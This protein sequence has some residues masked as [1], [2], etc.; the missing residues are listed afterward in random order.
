MFSSQIVNALT[1]DPHVSNCFEGV[2]PCD[3]LPQNVDF[4]SAFVANTDPSN[5]KGEHWVCYYFDKNGNAEYFDSFG[6]PPSNCQLYNFFQRN[7]K[8]HKY[9]DVQIQGLTSDSCGQYCIAILANRARG[10][11]L[12]EI[13]KR[14]TGPKPGMY[15]SLIA[16][17]VNKEY[18]IMTSQKK[19]KKDVG[20]GGGYY[21]PEQCCCCKKNWRCH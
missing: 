19:S 14:F 9:N 12:E 16:T 5:E 6:L 7:G 18:N 1:T 13:V 8:L 17:H 2:F 3:K 20:G 10:E 11:P 15:D 4:P 21:L